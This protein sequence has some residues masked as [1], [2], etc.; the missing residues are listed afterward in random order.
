MVRLT[1]C[2][3]LNDW[4]HTEQYLPIFVFWYLTRV[5]YLKPYLYVLCLE[6]GSRKLTLFTYSGTGYISDFFKLN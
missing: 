6:E 4:T 2:A 5:G 3:N 1:Q